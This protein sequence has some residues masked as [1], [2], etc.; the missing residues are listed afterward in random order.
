MDTGK[1]VVACDQFC[2]A[3]GIEVIFAEKGLARTRMEVEPRHYN[4]LQIVH[5]GAIFTL[6][7]LAFAAAT[8]IGDDR[9]VST[10]VSV[11]FFRATNEGVLLA[12]AKEIARS[13][14]LLTYECRVTNA[15]G[16]LVALLLVNGYIKGR[17]VAV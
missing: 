6:A 2:R 14:K 9:V 11:S 7:D 8:N 4:G 12:E 15:T 17:P 5:G 16:D 3:N 10:S 1:S 13:K